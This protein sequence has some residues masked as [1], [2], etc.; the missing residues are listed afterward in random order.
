MIRYRGCRYG[1]M[2]TNGA[3]LLARML[4]RRHFPT[5]AAAALAALLLA[6]GGRA[7]AER[8]TIPVAWNFIAPL[9]ALARQFEAAGP[10]RLT[11]VSGSTGQLYAQILN[12]APFD[13]LLAADETYP[14]RLAADGRGLAPS[15]FTY[16]V[17]R[18][19]LFTREPERF[20]PLG[21]QTLARSDFRWLAIANPELAPYGL[22]A[23]ETLAALELWEPLAG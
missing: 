1:G 2:R 23:K 13:V 7:A 5:I 4:A 15:R 17:G 22:A 11:I 21:T 3:R 18:L 10:H 6:M 19:A 14:A 12:G 16:A 9:E 20:A 8:A